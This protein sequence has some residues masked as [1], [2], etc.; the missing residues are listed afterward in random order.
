[1]ASNVLDAVRQECPDAKRVVIDFDRV[2]HMNSNA[3]SVLLIIRNRLEQDGCELVLRNVS[4]EIREL[5]RFLCLDRLLP[6]ID[7]DVEESS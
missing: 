4:P 2:V 1:M 7:V 6:V 5:F 3:V